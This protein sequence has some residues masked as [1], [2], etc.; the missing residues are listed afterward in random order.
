MIKR[1]IHIKY[2]VPAI[3]DKALDAKALMLAALG[4]LSKMT[5]SLGAR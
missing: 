5:E 1:Y 2:S 3:Q 4:R